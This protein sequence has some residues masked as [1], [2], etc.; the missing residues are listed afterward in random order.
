[1]KLLFINDLCFFKVWHERLQLWISVDWGVVERYSSEMIIISSFRVNKSK[2]KSE[3][4]S[5]NSNDVPRT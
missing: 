5:Q 1:M 3:K 4:I 2:K